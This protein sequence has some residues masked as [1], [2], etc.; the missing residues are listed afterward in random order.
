MF[1][2]VEQAKSVIAETVS[3]IEEARDDVAQCASLA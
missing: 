2:D 3:A 1:G